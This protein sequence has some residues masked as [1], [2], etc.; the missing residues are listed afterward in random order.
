M[1]NFVESARKIIT[2]YYTATKPSE[3]LTQEAAD[4]LRKGQKRPHSGARQSTRA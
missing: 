4:E 3:Q 2:D 1:E